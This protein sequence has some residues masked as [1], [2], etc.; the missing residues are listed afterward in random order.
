[1]RNRRAESGFTLMELMIVV[2]IVGVLSAVAIPTFTSYIYKSRTTEATSFLAEIRQRQESYRAEFNQYA[3]VATPNPA[4]LPTGGE[5][6]GWGAPPPVGW[7]QLGAAPDAPTRFQFDTIAGFP[8][9]GVVGGLGGCGDASTGVTNTEFWFVAQALGDLDGD[10]E[11]ICFETTSHR[12]TIW[13]SNSQGW[14]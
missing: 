2:V 1:M 10:G 12:A 14:E 13:T 6:T 4:V 7:R 5:R 11:R 8:N 3:N 9:D